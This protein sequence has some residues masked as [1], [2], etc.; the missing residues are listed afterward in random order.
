M[1]FNLNCRFAILDL[2][3]YMKKN[4]I[5]I[6]L[7]AALL[8]GC[9]HT[10]KLNFPTPPKLTAAKTDGGAA[11]QAAALSPIE[12]AAVADA[13]AGLPEPALTKPE[14]AIVAK[15]L[16]APAETGPST[17]K[18]EIQ[19]TVNSFCAL[20]ILAAVAGIGFGAFSIY[21]GHYV[22]GV[23]FI[24][25]GIGLALFG[26]WFSFHWLLVVSLGLIGAAVFYLCTH[27]ALIKPILDKIESTGTPILV[28]LEAAEKRAVAWVEKEAK[29]I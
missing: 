15:S 13:Q 17:A 4:L 9:I 6:G 5:I 19:K 23:Q 12:K 8:G 22:S 11:V 21:L 25:G 2:A 14:A 27:Y 24:G 26:I 29:K 16:A 28:K 1:G 7:A 3:L 18:S 10:P 20:M